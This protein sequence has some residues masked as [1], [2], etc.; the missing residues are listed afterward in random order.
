[1]NV[2]ESC[3]NAFSRTEFGRKDPPVFKEIKPKIVRG[4]IPEITIKNAV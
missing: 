3:V 4:I 1:M 2:D